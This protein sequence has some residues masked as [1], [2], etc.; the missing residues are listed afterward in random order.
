MKFHL[1]ILF[2]AVSFLMSCSEYQEVLKS[3]DLN[4]K[5]QKAKE[6]YSQ[7]KFYKALPIL[8][9]LMPVFKGTKDGE[10]IYYYLCFC[11]YGTNELL[12]AQYHFKNFYSTYPSSV[13]AEECLFMEAKCYM[14]LS[15]KITLDQEYTTKAIDEF[16]LFVNSFP[17]SHL[18]SEANSNID[19][20]RGKLQAKTFAGAKLYY[21]MNDYKAASVA[22]TNCIRTYPDLPNLPEASFLIIKSDYIYALNSVTAK[23]KDRYE[24]TL[25]AY[26]QYKDKLAGTKFEKEAK[27]I[28]DNTT[29]NLNKLNTHE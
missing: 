17:S 9:E 1:A 6:Y 10:D 27:N 25:A 14:D 28:F 5:Y 3:N 26:N 13:H 21:Q 4:L 12:Y 2:F 18:V 22:L 15:P 7:Q 20:L 24:A 16:Q 8:E 11:Y 29:E 19:I 23:Q